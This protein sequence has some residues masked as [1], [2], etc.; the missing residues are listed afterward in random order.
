M[1]DIQ[2]YLEKKR[3]N[4]ELVQKKDESYILNT[5]VCKSIMNQ[6]K[7]SCCVDENTFI[8]KS[9]KL[10]I[11][12]LKSQ[13]QKVNEKVNE[14]S[15][16]NI[17]D[18]ITKYEMVVKKIIKKNEIL[19]P[20]SKSPL[21]HIKNIPSLKNKIIPPTTTKASTKSTIFNIK[22]NEK[23]SNNGVI[24]SRVD[25]K[26]KSTISNS[27]N[28]SSVINALIKNSKEKIKLNTMSINSPRNEW[29]SKNVDLIKKENF[30]N[31][32]QNTLSPIIRRKF[33]N[34]KKIGG[35]VQNYTR[36]TK[37]S[38]QH[39]NFQNNNQNNNNDKNVFYIFNQND[40]SNTQINIYQNNKI[41]TKYHKN[42]QSP[43][44]EKNR[45]TI[46]TIQ[47]IQVVKDKNTID[48]DRILKASKFFIISENSNRNTYINTL[49]EKKLSGKL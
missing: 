8:D 21:I 40:N 1:I 39:S 9:L 35:L 28:I 27:N 3:L 4:D 41:D 17:I 16:E 32:Q 26:S 10:D 34:E 44:N 6:T 38:P 47:T 7:F 2:Q 25:K 19:M 18:N 46:Q 45:Q 36:S 20:T 23:I 42:I 48:K 22:P 49:E 11:E 29:I 12:L 30:N 14:N 5:D 24:I 33:I 13:N 15:I 37:I 31:K 43:V